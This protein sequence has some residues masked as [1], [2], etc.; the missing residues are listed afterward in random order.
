M[1]PPV[2]FMWMSE[3]LIIAPTKG[4]TSEENL[5][6]IRVKFL[7]SESYFAT[8]AAGS[9]LHYTRRQ[10]TL[11]KKKKC[12]GGATL[13]SYTHAT[14]KSHV[15]TSRTPVFLSVVL[16]A[17]LCFRSGCFQCGRGPLVADLYHLLSS[18]LSFYSF[19]PEAC[20]H[21]RVCSKRWFISENNNRPLFFLIWF[22]AN[23]FCRCSCADWS[24]SWTTVS[25]NCCLFQ[26][27]QI[28]IKKKNSNSL[29]GYDW[30]LMKLINIKLVPWK[31]WILPK[32]WIKVKLHSVLLSISLP[33]HLEKKGAHLKYSHRA[34][35]TFEVSFSASCW[36]TK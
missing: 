24:V 9:C 2:S 18:F 32:T 30:L 23:M 28:L 20:V 16:S 21:G 4:L 12:G 34:L 8:H 35:G 36:I 13:I 19:W 11:K 6:V 29:K 22:S 26:L 1:F 14:L 31:I 33:I 7:L 10:V 5:F 25:Y 3:M 15:K 27:I 17:Q